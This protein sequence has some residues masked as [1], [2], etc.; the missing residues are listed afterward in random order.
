MATNLPPTL[1]RKTSTAAD[2]AYCPTAHSPLEPITHVRNLDPEL[3]SQRRGRGIPEQQPDIERTAAYPGEDLWSTPY[4]RCRVDQPERSFALP[5]GN[6]TL[7]HDPNAPSQPRYSWQPREFEQDCADVDESSEQHL[8]KY[9]PRQAGT[10]SPRTLSTTSNPLQGE[11][12]NS[13]LS[14]VT[15]PFQPQASNAQRILG[16]SFLQPRSLRSRNSFETT[17]TLSFPYD[18]Q[19]RINWLPPHVSRTGRCPRCPARFSGG[20]SPHGKEFPQFELAVDPCIVCAFACITLIF[21]SRQSPSGWSFCQTGG[22]VRDFSRFK[23]DE[24]TQPSTLPINRPRDGREDMTNLSKLDRSDILCILSP[25]SPAACK[26][27][28]LVAATTPQHILQNRWLHENPSFLNEIVSRSEYRSGEEPEHPDRMTTDQDANT[29]QS[30]PTLDIALRL[31][32]KLL[33]PWL[34]F[35]FGRAPDKCDMLICSR[36][37]QTMKV[38]GA[39]FRIYVNA[40]GS[41]MCRDT[42]TNGTWVDGKYLK[43]SRPTA[44]GAQFT[45]HNQSSIELLLSD[46]NDSMR[47][48]VIIPERHGESEVYGRKLDAYIGYVEQLGRQNR[49]EANAQSQGIRAASPKVG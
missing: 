23:M 35:T 14:F 22:L 49:N 17:T 26:A 34:G 25:G 38:S 43:E 24:A 27:V 48:F 31:T 15:D 47:F 41:L 29:G 42:S 45:L 13:L 46:A 9:Q 4:P 7:S 1:R 32:S 37:P 21:L 19:N 5:V 40:N 6:L 39:H 28:E 2:N 8:D 30:T 12:D 20:I 44:F 18:S 33:Y 3:Q 16:T 11:A 10:R 36:T